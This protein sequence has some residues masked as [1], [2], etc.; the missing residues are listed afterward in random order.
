MSKVDKTGERSSLKKLLFR[1]SRQRYSETPIQTET[2][3]ASIQH[4]EEVLYEIELQALEKLP[5]RLQKN[6][7]ELF[8]ERVERLSVKNPNLKYRQYDY[9]DYLLGFTDRGGISCCSCLS[10]R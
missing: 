8:H 4:E 5:E 3:V 10:K 7:R 2:P 6:Y 1:N 9:M